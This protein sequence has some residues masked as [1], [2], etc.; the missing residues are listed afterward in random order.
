MVLTDKESKKIK[1]QLLKQLSNFPEDKQEQIKGQVESMT[2]EQVE[3]FVKQ[4]NLNHM[5]GECIFCSIASGNTPSYRVGENEENIAILEL[6]PLSKGHILIVPK[7]HVDKVTPST[8]EL[9]KEITGKLKEKFK[10]KAIQSTEIKIMEHS[11]IELIPI[12]GGETERKQATE[13]ELQA[14][15]E[16]I[17]KTEEPK[18]IE[19]PTLVDSEEELFKMPPR[20]PN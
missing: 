17:L 1:E 10:P 5:G 11:L 18:V 16:E 7:I 2:P 15:Q 3:N 13:E 9:A 6:N 20:I 8:Q 12:Y 4:N 14:L 19:E